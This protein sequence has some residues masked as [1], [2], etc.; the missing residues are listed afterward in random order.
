M[1]PILN[2]MYLMK[3]FLEGILGRKN[4]CRKKKEMTKGNDTGKKIFEKKKV[5]TFQIS[6]LKT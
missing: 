4:V 3:L 1:N 6:V 2:L 5:F